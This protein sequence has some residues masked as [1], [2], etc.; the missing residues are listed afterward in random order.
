MV[1]AFVLEFA[2]L[3][4]DKPEL[5][6]VKREDVDDSFSEITL[7]ADKGDT[8]KLIGKDGKMISSIKT[9]IS[10]CKAKE[11]RAYRVIIK[12]NDEE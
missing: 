5:V 1:D 4:A 8:G 10:G 9:I 11:G 6:S 2:K 12:S 3:I 7:R